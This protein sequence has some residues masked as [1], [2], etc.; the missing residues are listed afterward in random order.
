MLRIDGE[1]NAAPD[2]A[3]PEG[4]DKRIYTYGHRNVQGIAFHPETNAAVIVEH[5]P[6]HSDETTVLQNGGNGGLIRGRIWLARNLHRR[7]LRLQS[8]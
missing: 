6:W 1:G 7:L 3:V 2:N 5:G 8:E 4:F